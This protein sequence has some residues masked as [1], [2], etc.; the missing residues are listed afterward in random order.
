MADPEERRR[1]LREKAR[2]TL[3]RW[4]SPSAQ[5]TSALVEDITDLLLAVAAEENEECAKVCN[6]LADM[7]E[8]GAG[9]SPPGHRLRQAAR[10]IRAR[11]G[12]TDR[13]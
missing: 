8:S 9:D 4:L 12:G 10:Q 3:V 5:H 7:R 11:R 1:V 13:G 2:A 6:A